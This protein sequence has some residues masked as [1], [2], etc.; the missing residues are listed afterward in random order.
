MA[1]LQLPVMGVVRAAAADVLA[2]KPLAAKIYLVYL[3]SLLVENVPMLLFPDRVPVVIAGGIVAVLVWAWILAAWAVWVVTR[4]TGN[5]PPGNCFGATLVALLKNGVVLMLAFIGT[6]MLLV[7]GAVLAKGSPMVGAAVGVV[8]MLAAAA[9]FWAAMRLCLVPARAAIG[10]GT[11]LAAGWKITKN[12]VWRLVEI[13]LV[14]FGLMMV[15]VVVFYIIVVVLA[16]IAVPMHL[17]AM[18]AA[19]TTEALA[20]WSALPAVR[21]IYIVAEFV[22]APVMGFVQYVTM[23]ATMHAAMLLRSGEVVPVTHDNPWVV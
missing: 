22:G 15:S 9:T 11:S 4:A 12:E 18:P 16:A 13:N 2:N 20:Q 21:V 6:V 17:L 5:A 3:A 7:F 1:Q 8:G 10:E 14:L 19:M 23:G